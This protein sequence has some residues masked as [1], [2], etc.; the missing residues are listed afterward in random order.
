M[1]CKV[2]TAAYAWSTPQPV[3]VT[4]DQRARGERPKEL[5]L[6]DP[7]FPTQPFPSSGLRG[8]GSQG[9]L[10]PP[11]TNWCCRADWQW[12]EA[13]ELSSRAESPA[14]KQDGIRVRSSAWEV[15]APA[16]SS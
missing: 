9:D 2:R 14:W 15:A 4:V 13:T 5:H 6:H 16:V 7:P 12:G 1:F 11:V 3:K 10:V 8:K